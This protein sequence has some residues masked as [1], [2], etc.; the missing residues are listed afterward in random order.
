MEQSSDILLIK[1]GFSFWA[2]MFNGFFCWALNESIGM[3]PRRLIGTDISFYPLSTHV[4]YIYFCESVFFF[5]NR[6]FV[7]V[8][9]KYTVNMDTSKIRHLIDN[10]VPRNFV[11]ISLIL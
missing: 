9:K 4:L 5:S 1:G 8:I 10:L 7:S 3:E 6:I 11:L 2:P